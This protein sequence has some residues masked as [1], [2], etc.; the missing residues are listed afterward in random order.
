MLEARFVKGFFAKG[1]VHRGGDHGQERL[2][3][4]GHKIG[5]RGDALNPIASGRNLIN[6]LAFFQDGMLAVS[7]LTPQMELVILGKRP[8]PITR[9]YSFWQ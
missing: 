6:S 9:S 7:R 4:A 3:H 1:E 5:I 2:Q 8:F